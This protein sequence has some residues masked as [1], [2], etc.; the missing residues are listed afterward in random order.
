MIKA[1]RNQLGVAKN[2]YQTDAHRVLCVCSAGVLRS[3][4]I[5]NVLHHGF[6]YN[7]R[8][9]GSCLDYALIPVS[10]ALLHWA[11]EIVFAESSNAHETESNYPGMLDNK[12]VYS[13]DLPDEYSWNDSGLKVLI[14]SRYRDKVAGL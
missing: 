4:T 6:G 12:T 11:D 10:E 14:G 8:S 13:L 2:P 9:A 3:P 5:A 1:T 7:T